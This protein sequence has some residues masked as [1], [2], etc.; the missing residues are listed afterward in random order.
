MTKKNKTLKSHCF[1]YAINSRIIISFL[2]H[3][4]VLK[5][6][7]LPI[8]EDKIVFAYFING[9]LAVV[10]FLVLFS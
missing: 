7:G 4:Y 3:T 5:Y 10:I 8:Y 6:K 9:L 2:I 1:F